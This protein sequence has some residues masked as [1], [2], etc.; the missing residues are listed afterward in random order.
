MTGGAEMT[1][2]VRTLAGDLRAVV[3]RLAPQMRAPAAQRGITPTRL[4]AMVRL[5]AAG[6]T[7]L[8]DLASALG[9]APASM[10]RLADAL[11]EGGWIQRSVDPD[12]GRAAVVALTD[13]GA[14]TLA[15]LRHEGA[16]RLAAAI[17]SL[18]PTE[19]R[20]LADAIPVLAALAARAADLPTSAVPNV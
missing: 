4:A 13:A 20:A 3:G 14:A 19:R 12:D 15:E 11:V 10:T 18:D 9:I 17:A 16:H 8:G 5:D 1:D 2:D 6:P 7:R